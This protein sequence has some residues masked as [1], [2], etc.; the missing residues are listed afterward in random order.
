MVTI[1]Y[2][3]QGLQFFRMDHMVSFS[4]I[5]SCIYN[6]SH[7]RLFGCLTLCGF[8]VFKIIKQGSYTSTGMGQKQSSWSFRISSIDDL[9]G[10]RVASIF[11]KI[12]FNINLIENQTIEQMRKK[13]DAIY[14]LEM[15]CE[16]FKYCVIFQTSPMHE[17]SK[18]Q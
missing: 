11:F 9:N 18:I 13:I 14:N 17:W 6:H 3:V 10:L 15:Q 5:V 16:K 2:I 4:H 8:R 12:K 1:F 7:L